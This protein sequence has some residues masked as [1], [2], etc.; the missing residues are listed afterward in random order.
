MTIDKRSPVPWPHESPLKIDGLELTKSHL[1]VAACDG[2]PV[3]SFRFT[4]S[5][6]KVDGLCLTFEDMV[7]G[8]E[9]MRL[10]DAKRAS[11]CKKCR[12]LN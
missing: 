4:F 8:Y 7:D 11:W 6:H 9:G 2:R 5:T 3:Q 1:V 10:W 12:P